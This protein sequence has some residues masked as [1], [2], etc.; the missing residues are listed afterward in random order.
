MVLPAVGAGFGLLVA[1][2]TPTADRLGKCIFGTSIAFHVASSVKPP[3]SIADLRLLGL[4]R[5]CSSDELK[6]AWRRAVSELHPDRPGGDQKQRAAAMAEVN[7]AY[8]RLC[9]FNARHGRLPD[10][11]QLGTQ[12]PLWKTAHRKN[13]GRHAWVVL[14][15]A[16]ALTLVFW[17]LAPPDVSS[18]P[19][20][21]SEE[22]LHRN[23]EP[24]ANLVEP[25]APMFITVGVSKDDVLRL[26]GPPLFQSDAVW[27]YGPSEVRFEDGLV[28]RW[29]SSP[30]RP[31]P[32]QAGADRVSP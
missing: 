8:Q 6:R 3:A 14:S 29:H 13:T 15:L 28:V 7:A 9:E 31:L 25:G 11:T 30:L 2:P 18:V 5:P 23:P 17:P 12:R 22:R 10:A 26:A 32:V 1:V 4:S 16:A 19:A 24:V 27:E 21:A 20:Y